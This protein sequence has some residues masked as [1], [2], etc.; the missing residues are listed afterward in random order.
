MKNVKIWDSDQNRAITLTVKMDCSAIGLSDSSTPIYMD[1]V[2]FRGTHNVQE[3]CQDA[4]S[5]ILT[6]FTLKQSGTIG[7][8]ANGFFD[9]YQNFRDKDPQFFAHVLKSAASRGNKLLITGHSLGGA[10][11]QCL[12]AELLHMKKYKIA[13]IT[14]GSPRAFDPVLNKK[15]Q[16]YAFD[17]CHLRFVNFGDVV[18]AVP[19]VFLDFEHTGAPAY[20]EPDFTDVWKVSK[21]DTSDSPFQRV[22]AAFD[23]EHHLM[24]GEKGYLN[25]LQ[26]FLQTKVNDPTDTIV[27]HNAPNRFAKLVELHKKTKNVCASIYDDAVVCV[28]TCLCCQ[29]HCAVNC[30]T[31]SCRRCF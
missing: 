31:E 26:K 7:K 29:G 30:E 14:F 8:V 10:I 13:L 22:W 2:I 16:G 25:R 17:K 21:K 15:L 1:V 18:T 6:D 9:A 5:V 27:N 24:D 28:D 11:S 19:P 20:Y 23:V 3:M 12:A 4:T